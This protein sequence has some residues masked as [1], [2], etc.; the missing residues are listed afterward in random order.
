MYN[1]PQSRRTFKV[2]YLS[3]AAKIIFFRILCNNQ[4]VFFS[5]I[6]DDF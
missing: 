3:F 1:S 4:G 5:K 6:I 2:Y